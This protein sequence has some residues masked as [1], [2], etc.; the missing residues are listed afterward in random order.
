[1]PADLAATFTPGNRSSLLAIRGRPFHGVVCYWISPAYHQAVAGLDDTH[2]QRTLTRAAS[3]SRP[4]FLDSSPY[5]GTLWRTQLQ[6]PAQL[7]VLSRVPRQLRQLREYNR[8]QEVMEWSG[9][10][11]VKVFPEC[12]RWIAAKLQHRLLEVFQAE[13]RPTQNFRL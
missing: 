12:T 7:P 2:T 1:L 3:A 11:L 5:R 9:F 8:R 6:Q 13:C 4:H 10:R